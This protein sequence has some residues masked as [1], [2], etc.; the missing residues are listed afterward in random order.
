[1]RIAL[2]FVMAFAGL[3]TGTCPAFAG[4]PS[5]LPPA[6]AVAAVGDW[7][8]EREYAAAWRDYLLLDD[9]AIA[10]AAG[11]DA[12]ANVLVQAL[13]RLDQEGEGLD[14]EELLLLRRAIADWFLQL[15]AQQQS[16]DSVLAETQLPRQPDAALLAVLASELRSLLEKHGRALETLPEA[17]SLPLAELASAV[18]GET[19]DEQVL[20]AFLDAYDALETPAPRAPLP[21]LA[22]R[23]GQYLDAADAAAETE[24]D[25]VVADEMQYL[26]ELLDAADSGDATAAADLAD[27]LAW[28]RHVSGF[29]SALEVATR[30]YAQSNLQVRLSSEFLEQGWS[31][32]VKSP[33]D[34]NEVI[35]GTR[36]RGV[37]NTTGSF[38]LDLRPGVTA[39]AVGAYFSG[40]A[41][42][43]TKGR[44][45]PAVICSESTSC[46]GMP[47]VV[48]FDG[49]SISHSFGEAEGRTT[50][51]PTGFG[52]TRGGLLGRVIRRAAERRSREQRPLIDRIASR[53]AARRLER[54]LG[55]RASA[56]AAEVNGRI[57]A[58][59]DR[60]EARSLPLDSL[61][62]ATSNSAAYFAAKYAG[63]AGLAGDLHA[64]VLSGAGEVE[65][66]MHQS[67]LN[68]FA[69]DVLGGRTLASDDLRTWLEDAGLPFDLAAAAEE[70]ADG[71]EDGEAS[72]AR[73]L[74]ITF[75]RRSPILVEFRDGRLTAALRAEQ[76]AGGVEPVERMEIKIA[77]EL[78]SRQGRLVLRRAEVVVT[79]LRFFEGDAARLTFVERGRVVKL[80]NQ[81]ERRLE[82]EIAPQGLG[83][84]F[85][86]P[87]QKEIRWRSA[88]AANGWLHVTADAP[89]AAS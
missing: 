8:A 53:R 31:T 72:A 77:Y 43:E 76:I 84:P 62:A 29:E 11:A 49:R 19:P 44:N 85:R 3:A 52:A 80:Q 59:L 35:L 5:G 1:M 45:G 86:G 56:T 82:A 38:T 18:D 47:L 15:Q 23:V 54:R 68:N 40:V 34:V 61:A 32:E 28:M 69:Q 74:T 55:D 6:V 37:S 9:L 2:L 64:P 87:A 10:A 30:R 48:E 51:R 16:P 67:W 20:V 88:A 13:A 66:A 83:V 17:E 36:I 65:I 58:V 78:A 41:D 33:T 14:R 71:E 26:A 46:L 73:D 4:S 27:Q 60:L 25:V 79:P 12:D 63:A 24:W 89:P 39:A 57:D 81:V 22:D 7:I 42:A 70:A 21:L 75:A 50:S